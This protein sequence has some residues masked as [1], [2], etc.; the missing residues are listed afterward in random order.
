MK[1]SIILTVCLLLA[2][3]GIY[4]D[5]MAKCFLQHQGSITV[6]DTDKISNAIEA[7][8]KGDT[9]YLTEGTFPN[10]TL[11]KEITV[12]GAGQSTKISGSVFISLPTSSKISQTLLEALYISGMVSLSTAM[13]GVKLKQ[14]Y[15]ASNFNVTSNNDDIVL[16]RCY[17][18]SYLYQK[19]YIK[20]LTV[21][22]SFVNY[23]YNSDGI[24]DN[25]AY[26]FINCSFTYTYNS[27]YY[28]IGN[29]INCLI[30]TISSSTSSSYRLVKNSTFVNCLFGVDYSSSN[31]TFQNCYKYTSSITEN[32]DWLTSN[33]FLGNDGT[34][35]G[36]YGGSNPY[37]L[38][39]SFPK[40]TDSKISVDPEKK[41]LNV[42][43][44]VS[45]NN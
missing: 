23:L 37:T 15:I 34:V 41:V 29:F 21:M 14:C 44:K 1:K 6:Y 27:S 20:G 24:T 32:V 28:G 45:T 16:D 3:V 5:T 33:N 38:V 35:V 43:L 40:V 18:E 4:A 22:N 12:R 11:N 39:P 36:R 30:S 25:S 7:A 8:V 9:L 26:N 42:S 31:S 17:I 13:N 19:S 2:S 10:F